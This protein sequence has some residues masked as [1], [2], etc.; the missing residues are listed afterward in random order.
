M[1]FTHFV[2]SF[3]V[4]HRPTFVFRDW[5]HPL[6]LNA[7]ALGSLYVGQKGNIVKVGEAVTDQNSIHDSALPGRNFMALGTHRRCDIGENAFMKGP[8]FL[9]DFGKVAYAY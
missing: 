7:I 5:T 8:N 1:F 9:I 6:L 2:P 3:P 4:L